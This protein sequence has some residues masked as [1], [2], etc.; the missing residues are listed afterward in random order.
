MKRCRQAPIKMNGRWMN[1]RSLVGFVSMTMIIIAMAASFTSVVKAQSAE[2]RSIRLLIRN[3]A[4]QP[5]KCVILFGHW[6]TLDV[7]II[8]PGEQGAVT[9]Q[10]AEKDGALYIPRFDGRKM[11]VER[12]ACGR[13]DS[14]WETIGD[15]PLMPLREKGADHART[16]CQS[17]TRISCS[18]PDVASNE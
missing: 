16:V 17:A 13:T 4:S 5:L 8:A 2:D 15:V 12:I 1:N 10:R 18:S 11:M 9:L 3:A 14:W 6:V 7:D